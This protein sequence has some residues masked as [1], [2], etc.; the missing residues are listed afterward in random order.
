[1]PDDRRESTRTA[2]PQPGESPK[3]RVDRELIELLNGLRV[4]LPGVQVL[5]AFLLTVPFSSGA[6]RIT[7]TERSVYFVTVLLTATAIACLAAPA[8]YHR[9]RF[10][11]GDKERMLFTSNVYAIVGLALLAL[12]MTGVVFLITSVLFDNSLAVVVAIFV[13]ATFGALWFGIPLWRKLD[14][15]R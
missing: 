9:V 6:S 14:E 13:L 10:R 12:A 7:S 15:A 5:M 11:E 3:E 2:G 4:I 8:A 1:V